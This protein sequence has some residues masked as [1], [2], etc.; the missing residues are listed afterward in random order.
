MPA[1]VEAARNKQVCSYLFIMQGMM[2]L[3]GRTQQ[4]VGEHPMG[5]GAVAA[6][7]AL[8]P[9]SA[10]S[11]AAAMHLAKINGSALGTGKSLPTRQHMLRENA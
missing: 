10:I 4:L 7:Q 1:E 3:P 8:P 2:S 5:R 6:L 9:A 11:A